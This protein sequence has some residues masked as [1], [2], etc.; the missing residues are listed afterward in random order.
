MQAIR[1]SCGFSEEAETG[2]RAAWLLR[3]DTLADSCTEGR[4]SPSGPRKDYSRPG[5]STS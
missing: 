2:R 5:P 3:L 1:S 4:G